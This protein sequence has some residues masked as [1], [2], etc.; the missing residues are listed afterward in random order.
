MIE[1]EPETAMNGVVVAAHCE[2]LAEDSHSV[3]P[4]TTGIETLLTVTVSSIAEA[5]S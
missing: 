2:P 4:N 1:P 3:G 5:S